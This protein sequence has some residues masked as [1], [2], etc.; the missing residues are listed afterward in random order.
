M[1]FMRK[2]KEERAEKDKQE[3]RHMII[4]GVKEE[5]KKAI[6]PIM[7]RQDSLDGA[8]ADMRQ[9]FTNL[10]DQ[11]KVLESKLS[12]PSGTRPS[13]PSQLGPYSGQSIATHTR[14]ED[15]QDTSSR[16]H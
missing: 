10:I 11:V 9:Q 3:I 12:A 8:Q 14:V 5:V 16:N 7:D 4:D 6:A 1:D 13:W 2:D 15:V